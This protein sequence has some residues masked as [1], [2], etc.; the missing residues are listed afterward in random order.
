MNQSPAPAQPSG[1]R[2]SPSLLALVVV[3]AVA[4]VFILQNRERVPIDFL[5]FELKSRTWTAIGVSM[6][7]GA[8]L[9]QLVPRVWKGRRAKR[10]GG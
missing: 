3:V 8:I 5:F 10:Q 1:R 4:V 7:L 6:V 9:G 2:V